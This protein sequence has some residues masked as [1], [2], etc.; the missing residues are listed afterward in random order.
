M[1]IKRI[2]ITNFGKLSDINIKPTNGLNIVYAPNEAG[3]TT[4]LSFIKYIFYGTKQKKNYGDI[5]FKER[6]TPWNGMPI[7]GSLE[8]ATQNGDYLIERTD[9]ERTTK[10]AVTDLSSGEKLKNTQNIG[11]DFLG[12]GEKAFTDS[13]FVSNLNSISDGQSAGEFVSRFSYSE[14][15]NNAY[16]KIRNKLTDNLAEL[17]SPKRKASSLSLIDNKIQDMREKLRYINNSIKE[18]KDKYDS[19][20]SSEETIE[21]LKKENLRLRF[22]KAC[23]CKESLLKKKNEIS[24]DNNDSNIHINNKKNKLFILFLIFTCI[25]IIFG[26]LGLKNRNFIYLTALSIAGLIACLFNF[27]RS[28]R[29]NK[30]LERIINEKNQL[31]SVQLENIEGKLLKLQNIVENGLDMS[32]DDIAYINTFTNPMID[33]II[34]K[35]EA[36]ISDLLTEVNRSFYTKEKIATLNDELYDITSEIFVL[37]TQRLAINKEADIIDKAIKILDSSYDMAKGSFFPEIS[38]KTLEIYSAISGSKIDTVITDD[39]F[40][41]S[42]N[43]SGHLHSSK[44]LSTGAVDALYFS[45]R[46]AIINTM[47][48][49]SGT[50]IPLFLDD[51][52]SNCDDNRAYRIMDIIYSL[53]KENQ[54]FLCT[55]RSR[56]SEYFKNISD[57]NIISL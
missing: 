4:L 24:F 23:E 51:I 29:I 1:F 35:N 38:Q 40:N 16:L 54:I 14:N 48:Q 49:K 31:L 19:A 2:N 26:I 34:I 17:V 36:K 39:S 50:S 27:S 9:L 33:D 44:F 32:N 12:I 56:E 53:S 22:Q 20:K 7:D 28:K 8:F 30:D 3:K 5:T 57:V 43:K 46:I 42:L 15:E 21:E 37:E 55:C 52:L 41:I 11:L 45:L 18:T 10:L 47:A 13:C 25:S 6:F